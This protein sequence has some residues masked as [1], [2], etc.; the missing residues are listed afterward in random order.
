MP[1]RKRLFVPVILG[2]VVWQMLSVGS[3]GGDDKA[4]VV[5]HLSDTPSATVEEFSLA[6]LQ[7]APAETEDDPD[8]LLK[9]GEESGPGSALPEETAPFVEPRSLEVSDEDLELMPGVRSLL[10]TT[11]WSYA[12]RSDGFTRHGGDVQLDFNQPLSPS[13]N[14]MAHAGANVSFVGGGILTGCTVDLSKLADVEG[15][16]V[17]DRLTFGTAFDM[18]AISNLPDDAWLTMLR[19]GAGWALS[20]MADFGVIAAWPLHSD[21]LA[22]RGA[23]SG[24]PTIVRPVSFARMVELYYARTLGPWETFS[25]VAHATRPDRVMFGIDLTRTI[26]SDAALTAGVAADDDGGAACFVGIQLSGGID[27]W[28]AQRVRGGFHGLGQGGLFPTLMPAQANLYR[29]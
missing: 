20:D 10:L 24:P 13:G 19:A 22:T 4:S 21:S 12:S 3:I 17:G 25:Y 15:F 26:C 6:A 16:S 9:P 7:P 5:L 11:K 18:F 8:D 23:P 29:N 28:R 1:N 27:R 2:V 14:L